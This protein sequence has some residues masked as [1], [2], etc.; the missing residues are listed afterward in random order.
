VV[1]DTHD[2]LELARRD[3]T[4]V[5]VERDSF[6]A[7]ALFIIERAVGIQ[8]IVAAPARHST[9][10]YPTGQRLFVEMLEVAHGESIDLLVD[11]VFE[12]DNLVDALQPGLPNRSSSI[13]WVR[14]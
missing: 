1:R 13:H 7:Q 4:Q 8:A 12:R 10:S 6:P 3:I 2:R 5:E 14:L 9:R 11:Q